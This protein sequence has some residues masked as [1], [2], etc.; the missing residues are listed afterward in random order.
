[1]E[2]VR[3]RAAALPVQAQ[4]IRRADCSVLCRMVRS[5]SVPHR[6]TADGQPV[7]GLLP[8]QSGAG[9]HQLRGCRNCAD[10]AALPG[11]PQGKALGESVKE[12]TEKPLGLF[13]Q[14]FVIRMIHLMCLAAFLSREI[15]WKLFI[16]P[17]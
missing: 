11:A 3:L 5:G 2:S 6:G 8:G 9:R 10:L 7:L 13:R 16:K 17:F 12:L 15:N 14:T 4:K 1:M